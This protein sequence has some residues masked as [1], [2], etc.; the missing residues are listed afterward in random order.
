MGEAQLKEDH[1]ISVPLVGARAEAGIEV[2]A[3]TSYG[4]SVTGLGMFFYL[5]K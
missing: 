1:F 4:Q 5:R 3:I 2:L